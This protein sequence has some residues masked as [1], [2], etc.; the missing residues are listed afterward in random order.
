MNEVEKYFKNKAIIRGEILLF[1][2]ENAMSFVAACQKNNIEILGIDGFFLIEDKIQPCMENSI[3]F[4]SSEY[5]K[6]SGSIYSESVRFLNE[7][8]ENLFFEIVCSDQ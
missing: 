3:D 1:S 4:S 6:E 2:K 7:K 8:G 5:K